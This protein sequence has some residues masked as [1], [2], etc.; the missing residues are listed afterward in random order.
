[1]LRF[2]S[3]VP[4]LCLLPFLADVEVIVDDGVGLVNPPADERFE[5]IRVEHAP[6]T[7]Y[8]TRAMICRAMRSIGLVVVAV[9]ASC[10]AAEPRTP[11]QAE[12]DVERVFL[13]VLQRYPDE[14]GLKT[15]VEP[16]EKPPCRPF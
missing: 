16:V 9:A 5:P 14:Q 8:D 3:R 13:E 2:D 7:L 12:A 6:Q 4:S 15:H 10:S 11:A 1:M